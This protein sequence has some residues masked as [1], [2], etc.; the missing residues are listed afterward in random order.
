MKLTR[1]RNGKYRTENGLTIQKMDGCWYIVTDD[2]VKLHKCPSLRD[3]RAI[4]EYY[5]SQDMI[6]DAVMLRKE[7][8]RE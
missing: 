6:S 3:A 8:V 5:S 1:V 4:A 2:C 7:K